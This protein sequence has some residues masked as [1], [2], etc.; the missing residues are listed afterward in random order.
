MKNL[1][2]YD[3]AMCCS[4]GVCGTNVDEKLVQLASFLKGLDNNE[5]TVERYNL[6][7]EPEAYTKNSAVAASLD[8]KG[9]DALPIIFIDDRIICS[10]EYPTIDELS[11]ALEIK[12]NNSDKDDTCC[13]GG[14]C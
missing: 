9:T 3:P 12:S 7:Q 13:S 1:K 6:S 14:C 11:D 10:G 8:D 5:I 2:I 4:T